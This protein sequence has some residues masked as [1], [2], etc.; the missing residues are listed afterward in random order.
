MGAMYLDFFANC[1]LINLLAKPSPCVFMQSNFLN[2]GV[3]LP[4]NPG[5]RLLRELRVTCIVIFSAFCPRLF[6]GTKIEGWSGIKYICLR[7]ECLWD[8]GIDFFELEFSVNVFPV[9]IPIRILK[10]IWNRPDF[11]AFS[12]ENA[13]FTSERGR[14]P[15]P[16]TACLAI[17]TQ[18][19]F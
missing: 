6:P 8:A 12:G 4:C 16:A 5:S 18:F 15:L 3:V 19:I 13:S 9:R 1:V 17:S 10:V 11:W 14:N 2:V 7:T